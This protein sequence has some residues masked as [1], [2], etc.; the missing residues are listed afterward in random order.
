VKK[1]PASE[2]LDSIDFPCSPAWVSYYAECGLTRDFPPEYYRRLQ[3]ENFEEQVDSLS[4]RLSVLEK[5]TMSGPA[6]K[7][8]VFELKHLI[9]KLLERVNTV[10]KKQG[11]Y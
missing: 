8:E 9:N 11:E 4:S 5:K 2:Q 3:E 7:Q 6:T 1:R 10:T